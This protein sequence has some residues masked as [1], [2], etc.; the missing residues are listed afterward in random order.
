MSDESLQML[1]ETKIW[2]QC[3]PCLEAMEPECSLAQMVQAE[4]TVNIGLA[5]QNVLMQQMNA[6]EKPGGVLLAVTK[7]E[8]AKIHIGQETHAERMWASRLA[9]RFF[10]NQLLDP[11]EYLIQIFAVWVGGQDHKGP[12]KDNPH[13]TEAAMT[14]VME[15]KSLYAAQNFDEYMAALAGPTTRGWFVDMHEGLPT[16]IVWNG[17]LLFSDNQRPDDY[18]GSDDPTADQYINNAGINEIL[19]GLSSSI[20]VCKKISSS[21]E[22]LKDMNEKIAEKELEESR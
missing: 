16:R 13:R 1:D 14:T 17:A 20:P 11:I 12:V 19:V 7:N 9:G 21:P 8:I 5:M 10:A 15:M 2:E 3:F 18:E 4:E 22:L 6:G